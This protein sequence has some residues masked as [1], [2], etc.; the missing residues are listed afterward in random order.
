MHLTIGNK[1]YSSWSLRPWLLMR[2]LDIPF[3]ETVVPLDTP[4][5]AEHKAKVRNDL[6]AT[7]AVPMLRDGD[8]VI[9]ET[10]AIIEYLAGRFPDK[11]VWPSERA[12]RAHARSIANEMHAGFGAIRSACPMNLGKTFATRDRGASVAADVARISDLWRAAR[13][14]FGAGHGPFLYGTFTAADAM[15]APVVTRLDTYRFDV[16]TETRNYMDAVLA[17]G[18]FVDWKQA[19]LLETWIVPGDE[20]D[21]PAIENFRPQ[22]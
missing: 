1:C 13:N 20:V 4:E 2:A 19:G 16:D 6:G 12:A 14:R 3:D 8:V 17:H 9:W 5:F 7:G 10:M 11:D 21:E 22:L 18:A 15:Y